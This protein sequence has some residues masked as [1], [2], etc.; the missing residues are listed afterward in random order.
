M[1]IPTVSYAGHA[2]NERFAGRTRV[3]SGPVI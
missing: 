3:P 2:R 1:S